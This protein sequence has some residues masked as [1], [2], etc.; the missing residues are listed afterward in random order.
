MEFNKAEKLENPI[1]KSILIMKMAIWERN[2]EIKLLW[3]SH[4]F[5]FINLNYMTTLPKLAMGKY[6]VYAK[7]I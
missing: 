1:R 7:N 6:R 5:R 2:G 3:R 4:L